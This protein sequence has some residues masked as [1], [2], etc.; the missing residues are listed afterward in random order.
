MHEALLDPIEAFDYLN[1]ALE[2]LHESLFQVRSAILQ[3]GAVLQG[4]AFDQHNGDIIE[5]LPAELLLKA[6]SSWEIDANSTNGSVNRYPGVFEVQSPAIEALSLLNERKQDFE[7]CVKRLDASGV[8]P[9]KMRTFYRRLGHG[10]LH[11]LQAWRQVNILPRQSLQT[12]GFTLAK[13]MESIEVLAPEEVFSRLG[14][15]GAFD[16]IEQL[17]AAMASGPVRWHTP[18][19]KHLRA[20]ITW[21]E[22]EA[23]KSIMLNASLPFIVYEGHWPTR[24]KFNAP[25]NH[26]KRS[27][28]NKARVVIDLPF[29][30]GAY[31]SVM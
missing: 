11:A 6:L 22:N 20:N 5:G 27:D 26:A 14:K 18:V 21:K 2:A 24:L 25:R 9:Y 28:T 4:K 29:R 8:T 15:A 13:S 17:R 31:L 1:N 12:V 10:R 3:P 7:T 23:R 30:E 16:V 19:N